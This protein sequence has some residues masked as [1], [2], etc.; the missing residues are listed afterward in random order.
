[1]ISA[2]AMVVFQCCFGYLFS[3]SWKGVIASIDKRIRSCPLFAEGRCPN[4]LAM[5]R[6]YL[7]PQLL[8]RRQFL[9]YLNMHCPC[10][11]DAMPDRRRTIVGLSE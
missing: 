10:E 2:A 4:Q 7:I 3:K 11:H 8:R 9:E 5:E 6:M 1:M